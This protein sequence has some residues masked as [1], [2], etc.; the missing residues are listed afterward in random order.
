MGFQKTRPSMPLPQLMSVFFLSD[1]IKEFFLGISVL[2][3][4]I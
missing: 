2:A 1:F 3:N 4:F